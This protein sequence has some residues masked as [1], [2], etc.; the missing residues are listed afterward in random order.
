M[1]AFCRL[2]AAEQERVRSSMAS[3]SRLSRVGRVESVLSEAHLREA[4]VEFKLLNHLACLLSN[5]A[6]VQ[7]TV[8][9]HGRPVLRDSAIFPS[10]HRRV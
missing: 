7:T 4:V 1:E 5:A 6:D 10:Q 8:V 9:P 2:F 3:L